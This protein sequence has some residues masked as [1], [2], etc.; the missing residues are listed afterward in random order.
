MKNIAWLLLALPAFA[1]VDGTVT[2]KTT[3][4][5]APNATVTLYKLGGAGM[6]SVVSVKSA[7]DGTFHM[8]ETPQGP[9][10]IQTAFEG[11]TYNHMLPPGSPT[12]GL[13][14]EVFASSKLPGAAR[15]ARHYVIFGPSGAEMSVNE[16]FLFHNDGTTTYNDPDNGTLKFYLPAE[17]KGVVKV[18]ATAPQGMPIDR[19]AEKTSKADVYKLDFPIKPG[20]TTI[21]LTY[22]L[23]YNSGASYSGKLLAKADEPTLLVVPDGVTMKGEGLELKGQEPRSKAFVYSVNRLDYKVEL[24]GAVA[25]APEANSEDAG[26]SLE[27]ISPRILRS[28][29]KWVLALALAV[30][31]L[32]FILLYRAQPAAVAAGVS[33]KGKND[34]GRG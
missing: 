25:A 22:R 13:A 12:N 9:H 15:V 19:A 30:L 27:E 29:M 8:N 23:P 6:E 17:A 24:T 2:N 31:A 32:G 21:E 3:G 26:P 10:L 20:E 28:N 4:K 34:R 16:G 14:L 1:A 7:A 33:A 11:V 5:P 18:K